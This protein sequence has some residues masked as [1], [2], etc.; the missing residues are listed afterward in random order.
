MST[1]ELNAGIQ[2]QAIAPGGDP[3]YLD[4]E[5]SRMLIEGGEHRGFLRAWGF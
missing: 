4:P 3:T 2:S 5:E 1:C